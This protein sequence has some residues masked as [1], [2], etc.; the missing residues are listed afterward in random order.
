MRLLYLNTLAH[1]MCSLWVRMKFISE[2]DMK[3]VML[4]ALTR[5]LRSAVLNW[6]SFKSNGV[7][8][9]P[10]GLAKQLRQG[11]PISSPFAGLYPVRALRSE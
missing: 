10:T 3:T 11:K 7:E 9:A 4:L 8:F 1:R 6:T 5:P 2:H